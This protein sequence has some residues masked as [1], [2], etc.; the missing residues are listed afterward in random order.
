M[1]IK[2]ENLQVSKIQFFS[3]YAGLIDTKMT[4]KVFMIKYQ[5]VFMVLDD[6]KNPFGLELPSSYY[7]T[8]L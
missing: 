2:T 7:F 1:E 8:F 5:T 3:A 6:F 4:K